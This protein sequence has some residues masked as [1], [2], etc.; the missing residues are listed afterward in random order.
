MEKIE[1]LHCLTRR[2][3]AQVVLRT[4]DNEA[5]R[6]RVVNPADIDVVRANDVLGI[7]KGAFS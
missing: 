6:A 1:I 3:L 4:T 7:R 2:A 5:V